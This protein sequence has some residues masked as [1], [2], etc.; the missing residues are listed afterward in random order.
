MPYSFVVD[1]AL[2]VSSSIS[3]LSNLA[4]P[5]IRILA[6]SVTT[7]SSDF[8]SISLTDVINPDYSIS[9]NPTVFE[10]EVFAYNRVIWDPSIIDTIPPLNLTGL[11][12]DVT[13][14]TDSLALFIQ[15]I[16]K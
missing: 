2:D 9:V 1:R 8:T 3:G 4:D 12:D 13:K 15:L 10:D 6:G 5:S 7:R 16:R 11:V 14:V